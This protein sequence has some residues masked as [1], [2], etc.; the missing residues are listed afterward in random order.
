LSWISAERRAH[1]WATQANRQDAR[2]CSRPGSRANP[3][4]STAPGP[5][6]RLPIVRQSQPDSSSV[7]MPSAFSS[8]TSNAYASN[9]C[10]VSAKRDRVVSDCV[11]HDIVEKTVHA[12][13]TDPLRVTGTAA[14]DAVGISSRRPRTRGHDVAARRSPVY[15]PGTRTAIAAPCAAPSPPAH[16]ERPPARTL[17][18]APGLCSNTSRRWG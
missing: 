3:S 12:G 6:M 16:T 4:G 14:P 5:H 17:R 7:M 9:V 8:P 2:R 18:A 1:P 10:A 13:R 11:R 15:F